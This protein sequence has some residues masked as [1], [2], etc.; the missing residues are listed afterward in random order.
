M[1]SGYGGW[2][3][4]GNVVPSGRL[5]VFNASNIYGFGRNQYGTHGSHIGLGKTNFRLFA[6]S[7]KPLRQ[8][9]TKKATQKSAKK[10]KQKSTVKYYWSEQTPLV[11][12]A[13][14]LAGR[15]L[16]LAGTEEADTLAA[17]ETNKGAQLCVVSTTDGKKLAEYNLESQ[18]VFDGM[19][20]TNNRLYL[21]TKNGK[22]LCFAGRPAN[23]GF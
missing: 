5:L 2:P 16:F 22:I 8:K 20:A 14:V 12:R 6:A 7:R 17:L 23:G 19:A 3:T 15:T 13:M 11:V 21:A 9:P 10:K 4:V 1:A 18:P